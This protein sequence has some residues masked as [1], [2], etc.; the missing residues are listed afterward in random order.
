MGARSLYS[1]DFLGFGSRRSRMVKTRDFGRLLPDCCPSQAALCS[2]QAGQGA[3]GT[4]G[5]DPELPA[6]AGI[7]SLSEPALTGYDRLPPGRACAVCVQL[8]S[9]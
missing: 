5:S 7:S 1:W 9:A 4:A 6:R 3:T 8:V 2:A